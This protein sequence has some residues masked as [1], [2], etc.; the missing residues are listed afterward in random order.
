MI[1][2]K[3]LQYICPESETVRRV[4]AVLF[5]LLSIACA[6]CI[7]WLSGRDGTD[8]ELMSNEMRGLLAKLL[9]SLPG[10]FIVR[11]GAHFLEYTALAFLVSC[12]VFLTKKRFMPILSFIIGVLYSVSD[13]IHQYFVPGR[14]CRIFDVGV[15]SL[16]A[17][18]GISAFALAVVVIN[19]LWR[20]SQNFPKKI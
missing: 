20:H 2:I 8:S 17:L 18:V 19:S 15:D 16:G 11:K 1:K 9:G 13:E 14:A 3:R 7:F 12:A 4:L 10:S 5:W 6:V